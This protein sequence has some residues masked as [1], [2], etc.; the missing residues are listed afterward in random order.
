MKIE[1]SSL[2]YVPDTT[3]LEIAEFD[4][5]SDKNYELI[6]ENGSIKLIDYCVPSG[7]LNRLLRLPLAEMNVVNKAE[8]TDLLINLK[9]DGSE[10]DA[11]LNIYNITGELVSSI[12]NIKISNVY[13]EL[14]ISKNLFSNGKYFIKLQTANNQIINKQIMIFK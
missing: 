11:E 5:N 14:K 2:V 3:A 6:K 8:S 4:L 1:G 7:A 12:S 13:K 10:V 9:T